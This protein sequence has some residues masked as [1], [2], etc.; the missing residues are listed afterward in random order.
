MVHGGSARRG[1]AGHAVRLAGAALTAAGL[2]AGCGSATGPSAA[3]PGKPSPSSTARTSPP[4][5]AVPAKAPFST[6]RWIRVP[7]GAGQAVTGAGALFTDSAEDASSASTA[8][9]ITRVDLAT[10]QVGPATRIDGESGM[11]F[12]GGL[13]WVGRGTQPTSAGMTVLALDPATLAVRYTVALRQPP[14]FGTEQLAYAGGLVWVATERTLIAIDPATAR[15]VADVPIP[16]ASAQDFVH[17]AASADGSA[18]W[19]TE[20]SGGGGP[21]SVQQR[22]PRTGAVLAATSG[23]AI[24]L[25]GAQIA[26]ADTSAWLAF[27]TGMLGGY[28]EAASKAGHLTETR[29]PRASFGFTNAVRVYL[30]GR[31]LWITDAMTGTI[32]CASSATGRILAAVHGSGLLPTDIEPVGTRRIALLVNGDILVARPKQACGA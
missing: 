2:I 8:T 16:G 21:I 5:P 18:L 13:L 28:F 22:D 31:Q 32:A 20:N 7:G 9:L 12:G 15:M 11:A 1:A 19:V 27:A 6:V 17:V 23:P 4:L 30:P 14:S 3:N 25:G 10:G 24:G 29:P 26:A